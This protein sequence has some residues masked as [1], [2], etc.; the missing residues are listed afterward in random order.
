MESYRITTED[1]RKVIDMLKGILAGEI[2]L[3]GFQD[4]LDDFKDKEAFEK[5]TEDEFWFASE[6]S[7]AFEYYE[8][9]PDIRGTAEEFYGEEELMSQ[10][11]AILDLVI[12]KDV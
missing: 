10:L 8:P 1:G 12:I 5:L 2:P 11:K 4:K 9:N 7:D 6:I 3:E